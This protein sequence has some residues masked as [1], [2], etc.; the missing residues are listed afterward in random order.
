MS[1]R[2]HTFVLAPATQTCLSNRPVV[3]KTLGDVG[4][5]VGSRR[6]SS[7]PGAAHRAPGPLSIGPLG[8]GQLQLPGP[9]SASSILLS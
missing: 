3:D 4:A 9:I 5:I 8:S 2:R 1:G 7:C 6:V